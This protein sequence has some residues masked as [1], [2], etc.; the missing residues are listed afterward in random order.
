MKKYLS[1][2]MTMVLLLSFSTVSVSAAEAQAELPETAVR[3]SK[4]TLCSFDEAIAG[5]STGSV[6]AKKGNSGMMAIAAGG[7]SF[8]DYPLNAKNLSAYVENGIISFSVFNPDPAKTAFSYYVT[9]SSKVLGEEECSW[10]N[11]VSITLAYGWNTIEFSMA[12]MMPIASWVAPV[13]WQN[14]LGLRVLFFNTAYAT[15]TYLYFDDMFI[16]K[17]GSA[18]ERDTEK[19]LLN[20]DNYNGNVAISGKSHEMPCPV[21][22]TFSVADF[23]MPDGSADLTDYAD[24]TL[25]FSMYLPDANK[26]NIGFYLLVSS[27]RDYSAQAL[28]LDYSAAGTYPGTLKQGWNTV[29]VPLSSGTTY[30]SAINWAHVETI[31]LV[32]FNEP[33]TIYID[34]MK[35]TTG[36]R[37]ISVL[38]TKIKTQYATADS[39]A[40]CFG[41]TIE[42]TVIGDKQY[43]DYKGALCELKSFGTLLMAESNAAKA[44]KYIHEL[45]KETAQ[46]NN[47]VID[48]IGEYIWE[49][50][51]T[52]LTYT[53]VLTNITA[54][55]QADL[56]VARPYMV[57]DDGTGEKT[58]YGSAR[59][60]SVNAVLEA[61]EERTNQDFLR[62]T[63]E[64]KL[65]FFGDEQ[66]A[67]SDYDA[68]WITGFL[69]DNAV[70]YFA[71][72]FEALYADRAPEFYNYAKNGAS[73]ST[74]FQDVV[75]QYDPL[76]TVRPDV[77]FIELGDNDAEAYA[78]GTGMSPSAYYS[79]LRSLIN[80][81]TSSGTRIVVVAP[82]TAKPVTDPIRQTLP[83]FVDAAKA[84]CAGNALAKCIDFQATA[85]ATAVG[86]TALSKTT[87]EG[88]LIFSDEVQVKLSSAMARDLGYVWA[89]GRKTD[90]A[91]FNGSKTL[92]V[93]GDSISDC[94]RSDHN[95]GAPIYAGM[96]LGYGHAMGLKAYIDAVY[97][98][99]TVM[100][101]A[102]SGSTTTSLM[103]RYD[104]TVGTANPDY[105]VVMIGV[106]DAAL[107]LQPDNR[108]SVDEMLATARTNL[109]NF[110]EKSKNIPRI[111]FISPYW[112]DEATSDT[113]SQYVDPIA[114]LTIEIASQYDNV[115]LM[116]S[117]PIID[118][119][120][121]DHGLAA[122]APDRC[123]LATKGYRVFLTNILDTLGW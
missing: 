15:D 50:D 85:D 93:E 110:F 41:T 6:I 56:V 109:T 80:G 107:W 77:I 13:D 87:Q 89:S 71:Y 40:L 53:A 12:D 35:I 61:E 118:Q 2:L 92:L 34:D 3:F 69:G 121:K 74:I 63:D 20:F 24:G 81:I 101:G 58:I 116:T 115:T 29:E 52:S 119:A 83:L 67:V 103:S 25:Q 62:M 32:V 28:M 46:T 8:F 108:I 55:H 98:G 73:L 94:Y 90:S 120:V 117:Q 49:Q 68:G 7:Y 11:E 86:G 36:T 1:I 33:G 75:A 48:C 31:R 14:V 54:A 59:L 112:A 123:H 91:A 70:G 47:R 16:Y 100:N 84:A 42:R 65:M 95:A 9:L 38:G 113:R 64:I 99:S 44:G 122:I 97:G 102:I 79:K 66:W 27:K 105:L 106:N 76:P 51:E 18:Q 60:G 19:L 111:L 114:A 104:S 4:T 96:D 82:M 45:T 39:Q 72:C 10:T 21:G 78:A 37:G 23:W 57:I 22:S 30:I 43:V 26:T 17:G 5:L 88:M